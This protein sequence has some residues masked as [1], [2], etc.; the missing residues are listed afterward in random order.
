M[1]DKKRKGVVILDGKVF[2]M[3][4]P[5][6]THA[7]EVAWSLDFWRAFLERP[8]LFRLIAY[9]FMGKYAT[10][11]LIGLKENL[12]KSGY[13]TE[14]DYSLEDMDYHIRKVKLP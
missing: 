4:F 13:L 5:I 9:L 7:A 10:R 2:E 1:P 14:I 8:R 3:L 6:D 12:D 11:E